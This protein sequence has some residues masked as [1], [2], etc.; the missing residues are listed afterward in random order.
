M[1]PKLKPDLDLDAIQASVIDEV[2]E[3]YKNGTKSLRSVAKSTG[4]SMTKV[5]KI[6]ITA[7][8]Y[9]T[10]TSSA[11]GA[12]FK[13]GMSVE[14]IAQMLNMSVSNVYLYLPYQTILYGLEEKSVS[15]DRQARYRERKAGAS[16]QN[17]AEKNDAEKQRQDKIEALISAAEERQQRRHSTMYV[18][19]NEKLRKYL[20]SGFCT[21]ERD[22]G[23]SYRSIGLDSEDPPFYLWY[24]DIA[25]NGRGKN[26]KTGIVL[27]NARC[28]YASIMDTVAWDE[29]L[30]K[31]VE[32]WAQE[33]IRDDAMNEFRKL[34]GEAVYE[35]IV[36]SMIDDCFPKNRINGTI[37]DEII[38]VKSSRTT[39]SKRVREL[40]DELQDNLEPGESPSERRVQ[41]HYDRKFGCSGEYRSVENATAAC[42]RMSQNEYM[43]F[44][45]KQ[46]DVM[47]AK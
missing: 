39:P 28:G 30:D 9:S 33:I 21:D 22:P 32:D 36:S 12:A 4:F 20:P 18:A 24:A 7:E 40:C 31:P 17:E 45:K 37:G 38:F 47:F 41:N 1:K 14:E 16:D 8:V 42:L 46:Y 34:M 19:V 44:M 3:L 25:V 26:K 11:V 23:E 35:S 5:R 43:E 10:E 6:L 13:N 29:V 15:A 27:E 2:V